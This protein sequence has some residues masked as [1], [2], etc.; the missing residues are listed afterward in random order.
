VTAARQNGTGGVT[1]RV[2]VVEENRRAATTKPRRCSTRF[3]IAVYILPRNTSWKKS[4]MSA[5]NPNRVEMNE[6]TVARTITN[7][8]SN[9]RLVA[10][11]LIRDA[12]TALQTNPATT[13][14]AKSEKQTSTSGSRI[15]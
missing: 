4:V 1:R 9:I 3:S 14:K 8:P 2:E 13:G 12:I 11:A 5:A 7:H 10:E 6:T 15:P